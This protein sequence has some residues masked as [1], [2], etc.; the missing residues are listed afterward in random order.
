[1]HHA[2]ITRQNFTHEYQT[3][4]AP[5]AICA[6]LQ[7][8]PNDIV[9]VA[10]SQP[11]PDGARIEVPGVVI[12]LKFCAVAGWTRV[13]TSGK[14]C[15]LWAWYKVL[16]I[17]HPILNLRRADCA[18][19]VAAEKPQAP[20]PAV[21]VWKV[22]REFMNDSQKS[23]YVVFAGKA[24]QQ[25][26]DCVFWDAEAFGKILERL[27]FAAQRMREG[28]HKGITRD[29]FFKKY[30][31]LRGF[32]AHISSTQAQKYREDY[33][34]IHNGKEILGRMHVTIGASH[35]EAGCMSVHFEYCTECQRIVIVR[36]GKH[37]RTY[38]S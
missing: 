18:K 12:R 20:K 2:P 4:A 26:K 33:V 35:N 16:A 24:V 19:D 15:A 7:R 14:S 22:A 6:T 1:M 10:V 31:N 34:A 28:G 5:A 30:V 29:T 17:L 8:L 3:P 36:C 21:S 9:G 11:T 23:R 27:Y 38:R 32:R 13:I 25:A 37:G